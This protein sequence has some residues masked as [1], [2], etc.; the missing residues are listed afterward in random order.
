MYWAK[1][2]TYLPLARK[3]TCSKEGVHS[4][5]N[6]VGKSSWRKF[7][8]LIQLKICRSFFY[9][10]ILPAF[11]DPEENGGLFLDGRDLVVKKY[12]SPIY[13]ETLSKLQLEKT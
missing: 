13:F 8:D 7:A 4:K 10:G 5:E 6:G 12:F 2:A 3:N 1:Q 9:C 11:L